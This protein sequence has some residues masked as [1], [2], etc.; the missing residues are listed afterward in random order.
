MRIIISPAKKMSADED[1][2]QYSS[3]P[4]FLEDSTKIMRFI[5]SLTYEQAKELWINNIIEHQYKCFIIKINY[6]KLPLFYKISV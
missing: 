2:L 4:V 6:Y 1:S 3:L 5:Q